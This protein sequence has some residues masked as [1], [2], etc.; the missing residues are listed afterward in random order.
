MCPIV[1][2]APFLFFFLLV[3]GWFAEN[4]FP[5]PF[6]FARDVVELDEKTDVEVDDDDDETSND[7]SHPKMPA[8]LGTDGV[9]GDQRIFF[10]YQ[11]GIFRASVRERGKERVC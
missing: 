8:Q 3:A 5:H 6:F 4:P 9:N 11:K 2:S 7:I 1:C 10:P